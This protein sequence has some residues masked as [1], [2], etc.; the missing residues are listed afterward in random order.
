MAQRQDGRQSRWTQ[1]N[2]ERRLRILDA[3]TAVIEAGPPGEEFHV[4]QIA[5]QAGLNR[6]AVYR[7]FDDRADLDR[8]IRAHV[9]DG[10]TATLLPAVN[11]DG[12]VNEIIRRIVSTYVDWVVEHRALHA[13]AVHEVSGPAEQGADQIAAALAE[14]LQ[15]V[16][17]VLGADLDDDERALVDPLAHGLVGA[18]FGAVRRWVSLEPRRPD[19]DRVSE[20]LAHSVWSLLDGHARRIGLHLDPDRPIVELLPAAE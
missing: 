17:V 13:F 10:L 5:E 7:H 18:V 6:T 2:A 9:L 15:T 1:H 16:I 3:A 8:A 14:L 12:T 4:Q 20:L 11:L 19:A